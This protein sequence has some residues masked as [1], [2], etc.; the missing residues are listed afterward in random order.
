MVR[1]DFLGVYSTAVPRDSTR[2]LHQSTRITQWN[3]KALYFVWKT[4]TGIYYAQAINSAF[5]PIGEISELD[6][7]VFSLRYV[8]ENSILAVPITKFV[9]PEEEKFVKSDTYFVEEKKETESLYNMR[10]SAKEGEVRRKFD[11]A[12]EKV[13]KKGIM[14]AKAT[15]DTL[16]STQKDIVPGHKHMFTDFGIELRKLQQYALAEKAFQKAY[17]LNREDPNVL[18]NLGR[19]YYELNKKEVAL[20]YLNAAVRIE[21]DHEEALLL[22][23]KIK[24]IYETV[25]RV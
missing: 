1:T 7:N 18:F 2:S 22:I 11:K 16:L 19:L 4:S 5:T 10:A 24:K 12:M 14:A 9:S 23:K 13:H 20:Q 21:E 15:L 17:D 25:Y 6:K 3:K 8:F